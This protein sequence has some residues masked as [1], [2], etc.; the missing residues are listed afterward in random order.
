MACGLT[1]C[2]E[3]GR[4]EAKQAA[5]NFTVSVIERDGKG[6]FPAPRSQKRA[7]RGPPRGFRGVPTGP[8]DLYVA[9]RE[10]RMASETGVWAVHSSSG[11]ELE[12]WRQGTVRTPT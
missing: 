4:V 3:G 12:G 7:S 9:T 11:Q 1:R 8:H 2:R 10:C 6:S 5:A